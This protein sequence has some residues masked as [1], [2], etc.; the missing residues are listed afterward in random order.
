MSLIRKKK[1]IQKVSHNQ[2]DEYRK[3][4]FFRTFLMSF[5]A[6]TRNKNVIDAIK[7]FEAMEINDPD[8]FSKLI[9]E[10]MEYTVGR[11][12]FIEETENQHI[13][14]LKIPE[15]KATVSHLDVFDAIKKAQQE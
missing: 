8:Y 9:G 6:F 3:N 14:V 12:I 11:P 10:Y 2:N 1:S 5:Y 15:K 7:E 4:R 13:N